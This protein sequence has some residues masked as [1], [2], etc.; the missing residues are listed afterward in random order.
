MFLAGHIGPKIRRYDCFSHTRW[1]LFR[2]IPSGLKN[3]PAAC[4]RL[5]NRQ[6]GDFNV[7]TRMIFVF[8]RL[9]LTNILTI[10]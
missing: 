1:S 7:L 3:A 10:C 9:H 8:F 4:V 6:L 5:M 2:R